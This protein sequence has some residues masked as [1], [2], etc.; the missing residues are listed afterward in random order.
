MSRRYRPTWEDQAATGTAGCLIALVIGA[1][2]V[3][4]RAFRLKARPYRPISLT[5][6]R[7]LAILRTL[8]IRCVAAVIGSF[9][10]LAN[11]T[12]AKDAGTELLFWGGLVGCVIFA[13]YIG[14]QIVYLADISRGQ[15]TAP[16][17][18]QAVD[19]KSVV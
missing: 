9:L 10:C 3:C 13:C 2:I 14:W 5:H 18:A 7:D 1:V 8:I 12:S 16:P 11:A 4:R 17:L 6:T 15:F 19:R